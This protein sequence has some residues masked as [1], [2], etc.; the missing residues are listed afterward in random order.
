MKPAAGQL[1]PD[2]LPLLRSLRRAIKQDR[3][4]PYSWSEPLVELVA[5]LARENDPEMVIQAARV[6]VE[7]QAA[8]FRLLRMEKVAQTK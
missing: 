7:M 5:L 2:P 6:L 1:S 3:P 8:G 4:I